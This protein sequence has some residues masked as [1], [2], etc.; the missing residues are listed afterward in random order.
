MKRWGIGLA[1]VGSAGLL[2]SGVMP[3]QAAVDTS[4][5]VVASSNVQSVVY[6]T[7]YWDCWDGCRASAVLPKSWRYVELGNGEF[8]FVDRTAPRMIRFGKATEGLSTA[9]T[10]KRKLATLKG[11]HGLKVLGV[12]TTRM[13]STTQQGPLTVTT[14]VYTYKSGSTTRWVATRYVAPWGQDRLNLELTVGGRLKDRTL[15][16]TVL[17][18]ATQTVALAG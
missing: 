4:Q 6:K 10:A 5:K 14:V 1:V 3:A 2:F 8:R 9:A 18:K 16:T 17:N 7:R 15:L 12:K 13:T 11:T